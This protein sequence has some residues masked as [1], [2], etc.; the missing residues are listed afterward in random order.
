MAALTTSEIKVDG[1]ILSRIPVL[2]RQ[3]NYSIWHIKIRNTLSTYGVWEIVEGTNTYA[4]TIAADQEKWKLLDKRVLGLIASTLDDSLINHVS[5]M[6]APPVGTTAPTFPSVAKALMDKLHA[7]FGVTGLAGQFLLFHRAMWIRVKPQTA[8]ENISS[9]IQLFDQLHQAGLDLPQSFRAMILL[10]HLPDDMFTLASTI[11][12]TIAAADFNV[13]TIASRTL[14]EI[15]LQA[16]RRPLASR[17]SAIQSEDPSANRTTVIWHGPP[18]Q[19]QWKGQT[20]SYQNKPPYQNNYQSGQNQQGSPASQQRQNSQKGKGPERARN[21]SKQQ[22]KSW[23]EQRKKQQQQANPKG[24]GKANE[25]MFVNEVEMYNA[26]VENGETPLVFEENDPLF[27]DDPL[28]RFIDHLEGEE[29]ELM[30]VDEDTS[31]TVAHAGWADDE[32]SGLNIAGP[33]QPFRLNSF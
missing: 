20:N 6:W 9:L 23:Y 25:V 18:P 16:T 14:A 11:T 5:Y 22:K 7:L 28:F 2:V 13:E 19:N 21:P 30:D 8:N 26:S 4:S 32:D 10:S 1:Q 27:E 17:I 33:S 31:S 29:G 15:D 12:Q 24:K 3:S